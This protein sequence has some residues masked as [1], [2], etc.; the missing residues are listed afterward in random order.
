MKTQIARS[1]SAAAL[2]IALLTGS[3]AAFAATPGTSTA[4]YDD[5]AEAGEEVASGLEYGAAALGV[6]GAI[7]E[8][9]AGNTVEGHTTA[10]GLN[11]GAT[12]VGG[13][14][15]PIVRIATR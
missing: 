10:E 7:V 13:V 4:F 3:T 5:A 12:A 2:A 6:G 15:A 8:A 14:A 9:A 11:I 1:L